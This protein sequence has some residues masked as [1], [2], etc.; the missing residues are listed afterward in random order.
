MNKCNIL[1]IISQHLF[2][3]ILI[4]F[5]KISNISNTMIIFFIYL[6]LSKNISYAFMNCIVSTSDQKIHI[7]S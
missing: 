3:T 4:P 5:N 7:I 1:I 6:F 2:I